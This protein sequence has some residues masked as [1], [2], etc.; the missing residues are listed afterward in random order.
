MFTRTSTTDSTNWF[1]KSITQNQTREWFQETLELEN[2]NEI[3]K[4]LKYWEDDIVLEFQVILRI[5]RVWIQLMY[6]HKW[7]RSLSGERERRDSELKM[8]YDCLCPTYQSITD[9]PHGHNGRSTFWQSQTVCTISRIIQILVLQRRSS[10]GRFATWYQVFQNAFHFLI[11]NFKWG[12]CSNMDISTDSRV[13]M[14]AYKHNVLVETLFS[15]K[16]TK[17]M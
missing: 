9:G 14:H 4:F 5:V 10:P 1:D 11:L 7:Q 15:H 12:L 8:T 17:I 6:A 13:S 16:L 2:L 3:H